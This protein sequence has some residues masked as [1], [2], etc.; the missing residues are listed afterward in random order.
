MLDELVSRCFLQLGL[1][2]I[3]TVWGG[4]NNLPCLPRHHSSLSLQLLTGGHARVS[5]SQAV[6]S[7]QQ[8][9]SAIMWRYC[10][11]TCFTGFLDCKHAL[12]L[13]KSLYDAVPEYLKLYCIGVSSPRIGSRLWSEVKGNLKVQKSKTY[14]DNCAMKTFQWPNR[15]AGTSFQHPAPPWT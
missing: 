11:M 8:S 2:S 12:L 5:A 10:S 15:G 6:V 13:Y 7:W 4:E 9:R 3:T 14:F 1:Y